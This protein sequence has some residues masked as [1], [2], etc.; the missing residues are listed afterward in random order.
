M[1]MELALC[2]LQNLVS[3][4]IKFFF[5]L[6]RLSAIGTSIYTLEGKKVEVW[7]RCK[8]IINSPS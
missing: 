6:Q 8:V 3:L 1:V 7:K 2:R 4:D 5:D